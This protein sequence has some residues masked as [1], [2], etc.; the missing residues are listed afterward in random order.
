MKR[1]DL[2]RG[3]PAT[4]AVLGSTGAARAQSA[5]VTMHVAMSVVNYDAAPLY[6]AQRNGWFT[7]AGLN[8]TIDRISSGAA[9]AAAV[10]S[11]TIAIGKATTMAVLSG[12]GR[13]VPFRI[14]APADAAVRRGR[15]PNGSLC[16]AVDSPI[17]TAADFNGKTL[18]TA[19]I[20][21]EDHVGTMAWI[22]QHGGDSKSVHFTETALSVAPVVGDRRAP[23]RRR[24]HYRAALESSDCRRQGEAADARAQRVRKA[25][26]VLG[27][28]FA[29]ARPPHRQPI[30][31]AVQHFID[32]INCARRS[33]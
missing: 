19:S 25:F 26:P 5:P 10:A 14:I 3:L 22:D 32:T 8:V 9:T 33:T 21:S 4:V 17:K 2:L 15:I 7:S 24:L 28:G 31:E 6:Y 20:L 1:S 27:V 30:R 29:S 12:F 18:G 23:D 11:Q 13:N 16:V